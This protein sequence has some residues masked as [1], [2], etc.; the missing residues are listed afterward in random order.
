MKVGERHYRTVWMQDSSVF[1]IDQTLL[2]FKFEVCEAKTYLETCKAIKDMVVRGAGAIGATAGYAMAQAFIQSDDDM[3][4]IESARHDIESTRPTAQNLF[5]ATSRV[6]NAAKSGYSVEA[7]IKEAQRIAYEDAEACRKIGECGASL[8][9][10][11]FGIETHCNAGWLAFVDYGTALSP[12]YKVHSEGKKTIVYV[13]ETGPRGQGAKLTAWE[14]QNENVPYMILPDTAGADLMKTGKINLVI[15]GADR[16]AANGD[17]ANKIGT[18]QKAI[19]AEHF[20]IPF[21]SAAPTSTIDVN[22]KSGKEI[23][24]EHRS[25]DEVL[26]QTGQTRDGRIESVL[27]CAPGA[28]VHNPAFDVTPAELITGIVTEKGIIKPT[29][30]EI[31]KL[32]EAK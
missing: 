28:S 13:D 3:D 10:D 12:I 17:T 18:Y 26:Y 7:A 30:E 6:Y 31:M 25:A 16:I 22:C 2:P 21:Y 8:I 24:V 11:G 9:K 27:V 15:V 14:L 4:F 5:Y 19:L 20:V 32:F 23:P 29:E 1:L